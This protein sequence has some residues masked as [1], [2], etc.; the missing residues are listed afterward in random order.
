MS[1]SCCTTNGSRLLPKI[2]NGYDS[3]KGMS[4][5]RRKWKTSKGEEREAWV[6]RYGSGK[7][8]HIATFERKKE[9]EDYHAKVRVDRAQ[10]IH[11]APSQSITVEEAGRLWI[12]AAEAAGLER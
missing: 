6:D 11:I 3:E 10:G 1:R 5:R 8:R 2:P 4:V 12:E 9:A 7:D